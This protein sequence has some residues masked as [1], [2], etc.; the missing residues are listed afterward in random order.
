MLLDNVKRLCDQKGISIWSLEKA[1]DAGNGTIGKWGAR[2]PRVE[3]VKKVA[4][5]FGV[6]VDQLLEDDGNDAQ[7]DQGPG[8]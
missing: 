1:I 7:R 3:T 5:Y 6:T 4:D 8:Q 2:S